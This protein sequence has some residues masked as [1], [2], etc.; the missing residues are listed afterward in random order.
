M[1]E[2][3]LGKIRINKYL[4]ECGACS[5]RGADELIDKGAVI[6]DGVPASRGMKI[7]PGM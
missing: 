5:R 4:A 6:V 1:A 2:A 7:E 3:E